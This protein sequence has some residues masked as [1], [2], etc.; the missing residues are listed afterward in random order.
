MKKLFLTFVAAIVAVTTM[1]AQV[2][3]VATLTHDGNVTPY[4]GVNALDEAHAAAADGDIITLSSGTFKCTSITKAVTIHGACMER[5]TEKGIEPT[6]IS[7]VTKVEIPDDVDT[8]LNIEGIYFKHEFWIQNNLNNAVFNKC[9]FTKFI[10]NYTVTN[11]FFSACKIKDI[12]FAHGS[13]VFTNCYVNNPRTSKSS[14]SLEFINCHVRLSDQ[15]NADVQNSIFVNSVIQQTSDDQL[16]STNI[17]NNCIGITTY[18]SSNYNI[19]TY[20]NSSTGNRWL[21]SDFSCYV[22]YQGS[23]DIDTE[24]F[25]LTDEAKAQYLGNDGT[26]VGM[27]GGVMPFNPIPLIPW[28]SKCNVANRATADGKLSVDIEVSVP[29]E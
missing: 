4:Y 13:A 12:I 15:S 5:N 16:T 21:G 2:T 19:F 25:L 6:F 10:N 7:G 20:L 22:S 3:L 28:I 14:S 9:L 17:A 11:A 18:L 29:E 24:Q 27:H 8:I 23:D 1:Q 26:E